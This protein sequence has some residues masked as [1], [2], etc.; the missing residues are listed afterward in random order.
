MVEQTLTSTY[1][2]NY[3]LY[4]HFMACLLVFFCHCTGPYMRTIRD[5]ELY[6]CNIILSTQKHVFLFCS[7]RVKKIQNKTPIT[8][9]AFCSFLF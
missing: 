6:F 5:T 7:K 4:K 1:L 3:T 2:S 9:V 8:S